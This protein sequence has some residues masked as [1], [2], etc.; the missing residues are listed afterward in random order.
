MEILIAS[1]NEFKIKEIKN[2]LNNKQIVFKSL[3]EFNDLEDFEEVGKTFKENAYLKAKHFG[4]K[5]Q[6]ITLADDS[7]IMVKALNNG[8]GINSKRYAGSDDKNNEKL[9]L[10]LKDKKTTKAKMITTLALYNPFNK[11][12][13]YF[14]GILKVTI[15]KTLKGTNGFGYDSLLYFKKSKKT[16]G[17][18]TL[19]E[20][21]QIS[22]RS[23]ALSKLKKYYENINN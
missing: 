23:K 22:H 2:I 13:K 18:M 12:V 20:K 10:E 8:P 21:D 6:M 16:L 15:S 17:E 7:G 19:A 5:H 1:L 3:K 14:S 9:L 11:K 4:D